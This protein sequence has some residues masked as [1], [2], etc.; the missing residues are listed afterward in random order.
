MK[1]RRAWVVALDYWRI[2]HTK[3]CTSIIMKVSS[4]PKFS[5]LVDVGNWF[6]CRGDFN[7]F[8]GRLFNILRPPKTVISACASSANIYSSFSENPGSKKSSII[9]LPKHLFSDPGYFSKVL[10]RLKEVLNSIY[11]EAHTIRSLFWC[12]VTS[13]YTFRIVCAYWFG[14]RALF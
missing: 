1:W 5:W 3:G 10:L 13:R 11:I 14:L 4:W 12:E 9:I 2:K 7:R 6:S 8:W